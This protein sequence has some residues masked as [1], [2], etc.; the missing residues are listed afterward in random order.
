M[1][2]RARI[3]LLSG[4]LILLLLAAEWWLVDG[5]RQRLRTE[6]AQIARDVGLAVMEDNDWL[7]WADAV[8]A[9]KAAM[10]ANEQQQQE[11]QQRPAAPSPLPG[12]PQPIQPMQRALRGIPMVPTTKVPA[13][14]ARLD[15]MTHD[16][17][18]D[19]LLGSLAILL[20][21]LVAT[22]FV[23]HRLSAP[24][25]S[26]GRAAEAI[27]AGR[28]GAQAQPAGEPRFDAAIAA[29]N[30]M[31]LRLQALEAEAREAQERTHL[32][33]L[34]EIARGIAH[35]LRNPLHAL[36]LSLTELV[37]P[38]ASAEQRAELATTCQLQIERIDRT[39]RSFLSLSAARAEPPAPIDLADVV[40][41]VIMEAAQTAAG[42]VQIECDLGDH[43]PLIR[44]IGAEL[45]TALHVLVLNAVEASPAGGTVAV[46]VQAE[47]DHVCVTVEDDGP[48]LPASVRARLFQPH[49]TTKAQGAGLGLFLAERIARRRYRGSLELEERRGLGLCAVLTLRD[50]AHV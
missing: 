18:V 30:A 12:Q 14:T 21:G 28:F 39:L 34:G 22:A 3:F 16:F 2:L 9:A 40:Q 35:S 29:F 42:R 10:Q 33:E 27:G 24:L 37:Q 17:Q 47:G 7:K 49:V 5:L 41:D 8:R 15:A 48:G 43:R 38:A 45:R 1:S 11:Q 23:A 32:T 36:G 20:A 26:L 46:R 13:M 44:G 25:Q 31:S 50:A 6:S 19:M 4:G